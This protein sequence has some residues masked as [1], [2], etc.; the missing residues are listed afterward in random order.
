MPQ[1]VTVILM[2]RELG[3]WMLSLADH[4]FELRPRDAG[5]WPSRKQGTVAWMLDDVYMNMEG[6]SEET[7][8][9][10]ADL[11]SSYANGYLQ[12]FLRVASSGLTS[13]VI[14]RY[15]D[16]LGRPVE[17]CEELARLGMRRRN[18]VPLGVIEKLAY[19]QHSR[20]E[21]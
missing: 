5:K 8:S 12:G 20:S 19:G 6:H 14:I 7:Y 2:M 11:W 15:E 13:V 1:G 18:D 9:S 16:M 21:R 17:V 4:A 3:S 10:I